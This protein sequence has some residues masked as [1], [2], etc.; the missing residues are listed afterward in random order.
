MP[1]GAGLRNAVREGSLLRHQS[2]EDHGEDS[3]RN[4]S[5]IQCKIETFPAHFSRKAVKFVEMALQKDPNHR[6]GVQELMDSE[7]LKPTK[8]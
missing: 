8:P 4:L 7:F 2:Q 6:V 3:E 5:L 1:G